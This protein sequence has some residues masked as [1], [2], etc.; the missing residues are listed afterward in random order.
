[1]STVALTGKLER[2]AGFYS[3]VIGKKMVMAVTGCILFGFIMVHMVANLQVFLPPEA[4]GVPPLDAYSAH[5]H[6]LPLLL[7]GARVVLLVAV[8]LH[9]V[10]AWQLT[11]L[12]RFEARR[13]SRY[14]KYDP[15]ASNYASRTMIWSGPIIF[16]YVVYHLLDL[17][18]GSLNPSFQ[19]GH[20]FHNV[21]A[22]FQHPAVAV[23]YI[24]ANVCLAFH[25]YHGAWSM[26]QTV[27]IAHPRY[28]PILKKAS[29][30]MAILI[31]AGFC[32]IPIAV[33]THLVR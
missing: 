32:S 1:L 2:V 7:W 27:G 10:A 21:V 26:C 14:V 8:I 31:G 29:A 30:V 18:F 16:F 24:V 23:F 9:I 25:L 13:A 17:T 19:T 3:S 4:N 33:M 11:V 28:T 20:V 15:I 6:A 22:D 5:L 12:N